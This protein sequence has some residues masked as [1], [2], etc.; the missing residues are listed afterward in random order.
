MLPRNRAKLAF[1]SAVA[2]DLIGSVGAAITVVRLSNSAAWVAHTYQV[3][4]AVSNIDFI[5]SEAGRARLS[6]VTSGDEADLQA[7]NSASDQTAANLRNIRQLT[8]DNPRQQELCSRLENLANRRL[9]V[10]SAA[11]ELR[12]TGEVNDARQAVF[13]RENMAVSR[14]LDN[15]MRQ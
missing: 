3:Q 1:V 6:Y 7:F 9:E 15:L 13:S 11:I 4:L 8:G 10:L 2:L 12:K 5:L 14:D